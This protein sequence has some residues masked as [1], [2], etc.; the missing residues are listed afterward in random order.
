MRVA[1]TIDKHTH[2]GL[3]GSLYFL[4]GE[5]QPDWVVAGNWRGT[6]DVMEKLEGCTRCG[7]QA[8]GHRSREEASD[9]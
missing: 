1:D 4:L 8:A 3:F 9:D 5:Q 6:D 2:I 7:V